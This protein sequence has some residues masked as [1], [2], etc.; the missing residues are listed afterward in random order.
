MIPIFNPGGQLPEGIHE[1]TWSEFL[2][3][4]DITAHRGTL[5]EGMKK[6]I[7]H[8]KAVGCRALYVDGS[9]V[10]DREIPNDYD[11]CWDVHG[12][13]AEKVDKLL[14]QFSDEAKAEIQDKYKGDIR[15]D[16]FSPMETSGTYL[17]FFQMDRDGNRKG[18]IRL[19]LEEIDL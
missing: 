19:S 8:L 16:S 9:F 17:E 7:L 3:R 6:L 14:L 15:P 5:I 11:A 18:I 10:T 2:E 13:K 12:V 1:A 4:Y